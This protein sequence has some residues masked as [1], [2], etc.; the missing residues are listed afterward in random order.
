MMDAFKM[1][2]AV[3]Q[4]GVRGISDIIQLPGLVNVDFADVKTIM[5]NAGTALMGQGVASG[6]GRAAEAARAALR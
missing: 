6:K 5:T 3:L 1:A 4:S 2:D